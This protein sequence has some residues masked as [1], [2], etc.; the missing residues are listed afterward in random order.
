MDWSYFT[1]PDAAAPRED[2]EDD[3][4]QPRPAA[5]SPAPNPAPPPVDASSQPRSWA[6]YTQPRE[7]GT[8]PSSSA[9]AA[10]P[11]MASQPGADVSQP[12]S[13]FPGPPYKGKDYFGPDGLAARMQRQAAASGGFF[14][15][16]YGQGA[17]APKWD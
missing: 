10:A 6:D 5:V 4:S 11:A 16:A 13:E 7:P 3:E 15:A 2:D 1:R 8:T 17:G 12:P 14:A 9:V